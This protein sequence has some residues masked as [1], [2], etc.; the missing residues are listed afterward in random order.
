MRPLILFF[1][2]ALILGGCQRDKDDYVIGSVVEKGGCLADTYLVE[3]P[4][5]ST[6]KMPFLCEPAAPL[7][8]LRNCGNSVF[9][10]L[11]AS[12]AIPGKEIRFVYAGTEPSCLSYSF[13]P[14]HITVKSLRA[15]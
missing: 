5:A 6:A 3:I 11:P 15:D 10:R 9:I 12:L 7:S 14:Q 13:A 1:S 8:T 4:G 2:F